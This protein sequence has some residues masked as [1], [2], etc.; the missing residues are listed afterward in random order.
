MNTSIRHLRAG[1]ARLWL[2]RLCRARLAANRSDNDAESA[3]RQQL[4]RLRIRRCG[5]GREALHAKLAEL[6][7]RRERLPASRRRIAAHPLFA[8]LARVF[9]LDGDALQVLALVCELHAGGELG[10]AARA[11]SR[12]P[13]TRWGVMN[14]LGDALG[15]PAAR[16]RR[17]LRPRGPLLTSGLLVLYNGEY[18][19]AAECIEPGDG[20]LPLVADDAPDASRYLERLFEQAGPGKLELVDYPHLAEETARLRDYLAAAVRDRGGASVLLYGPPGTGKSELARALAAALGLTLYLVKSADE[21]GEPVESRQ[22]LQAYEAAQRALANNP[23]ALLMFDEIE[24]VFRRSKSSSVAVDYKSWI[25]RQLETARVPS[26]WVSNRTDCMDDS[27]LRRFDIALEVPRPPRWMRRALLDRQLARWPVSS[28]VRDEIVANEAFAPAHY[29]RAVRVLER[30]DVRDGDTASQVLRRS[31]DEVLSLLGRPPLGRAQ[32]APAFDLALLRTDQPFEPIVAL[33]ARRPSARLCLYG[34]PGTG[35]S[36]LAEHLAERLGL[37]LL[38][39]RASDLLS[40][41]VGETEANIAAMFREAERERAVLCLDEADSFLRERSGMQRSWEVTQVN[42]LLTR[43]EDFEGI[44]VASTNLMDSLDAA[45][46]R[47][48]DFKLRFEWLDPG[49][50]RALFDRYACQFELR[51][52]LDAPELARRLGRLDRLTPGDFAA[53]HRRLEATPGCAQGSLLQW[54]QAEQDLKPGAR[55]VR[56]GFTA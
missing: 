35:K 45:A 40:P 33:L 56:M 15:L 2:L 44:F 25:N 43:L 31:L 41:W 27:Q 54:L 51:A 12:Y 14:L 55:S 46:L 18:G 37:P 36:A 38:K 32:R 34:P 22:R 9:M 23:Q 26:L 24:D 50:R 17:C 1:W 8:D 39:R 52:D 29:A 4:E 19:H 7:E 11:D 42:E 10:I 49:Q 47:R 3:I 30:L 21:N 13:S 48:F 28:T 53:Q 5:E 6:L 20:L 16:L